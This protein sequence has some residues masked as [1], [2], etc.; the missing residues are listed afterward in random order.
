MEVQKI[1]NHK[2]ND[3]VNQVKTNQANSKNAQF[4][5]Y[6]GETKSLDRIFEEAAQKYNVSV[7]LLKAIGKAES[8]FNTKAVSRSG[9]QGIMQLM[10]GTAKGL[11]VKDSFDP[12]QNIMGGAKYISQKLKQYNGDV[13]LALAAYNAGS[14]N[15]AKYN[16]IPP[17]KETQNYVVKVTR[18]MQEGVST[19]NAKVQVA[20]MPSSLDISKVTSSRS[21]GSFLNLNEKNETKDLSQVMDTIFSY[22]DY[23]K[24]LEKLLLGNVDKK[25]KDNKDSNYLALTSLSYNLAV[26]NIMKNQ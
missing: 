12:E 20:S 23:K 8:D 19:N 4:S 6:L 13:K 26:M 25:E 5:T 1:T 24:F 3:K 9:A 21:S 15:V 7:D 18:Y 11:G 14:G 16:G 10:P 17:F 22:E 2:Q